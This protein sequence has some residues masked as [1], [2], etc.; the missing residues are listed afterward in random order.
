MSWRIALHDMRR[1]AAGLMFWLLLAFAQLITAWLGFAQLEALATIAPQLKLSGTSLG[2]TDLV[3]IPTLNSLVLILLLATPLLAM[4][5]F[6][7][8][9]HSGRMALWLSSPVRSSRIVTGKILGLWLATLPLLLS[10]ILTLA[11]F[12]LGMQ[13]DWPRFLL[14]ASYLALFCLWLSAIVILLSCLL[15]HPAA[16]LALSYGVLLFLW[17]LDS[18]STADAPWHWLAFLAHLEPGFRGLLRSQ[19]LVFFIASTLAAGLLATYL[20]ARR[21]G[22]V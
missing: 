20:I 9:N 5:G 18:I 7:G 22:E 16:A 6:A 8:E 14:A 19:D 3:L 10:G 11:L 1:L 17:L 21:R 4:G 13:I 2:V 12:G 15:D